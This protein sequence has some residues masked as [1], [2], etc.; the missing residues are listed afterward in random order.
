M[1]K[2]NN[3]MM[4]FI[5]Y[6]Y[7]PIYCMYIRIGQIKISHMISGRR[8]PRGA[9]FFIII[10]FKTMLFYMECRSH[11]TKWPLPGRQLGIYRERGRRG[12]EE[13]TDVGTAEGNTDARR[14]A[15][16]KKSSDGEFDFIFSF[17]NISLRY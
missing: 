14:N 2:C 1:Y 10:I 11:R 9:C 7:M 3:N 13:L 16:T 15:F 17:L 6:I 8:S 5:L 4:Y 12:A